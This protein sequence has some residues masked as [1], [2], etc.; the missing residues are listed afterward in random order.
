MVTYD[1]NFNFSLVILSFQHLLYLKS[2][3]DMLSLNIRTTFEAS[4][5]HSLTF[6]W[7]NIF[8]TF[9]LICISQSKYALHQFLRLRPLT[10]LWSRDEEHC[11]DNWNYQ[12]CFQLFYNSLEKVHSKI[13]FRILCC[14]ELFKFSTLKF[15]L[16]SKKCQPKCKFMTCW[17]HLKIH[18]TTK[19]T[20]FKNW[21]T[22][23]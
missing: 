12:Y 23:L 21:W 11:V 17:Y 1:T 3:L 19:C 18:T 14:L 8:I 16:K 4:W 6:V 20:S 5:S 2:R 13:S 22:L 10:P 9:L 15:T 7:F